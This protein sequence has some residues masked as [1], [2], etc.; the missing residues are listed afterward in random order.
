MVRITQNY[1][2]FGNWIFERKEK[3]RQI[4]ISTNNYIIFIKVNHRLI[5]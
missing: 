1:G 2:M 5:Y 4:L 3:E